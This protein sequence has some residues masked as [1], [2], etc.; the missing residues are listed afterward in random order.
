LINLAENNITVVESQAFTDLYLA[1]V[2][3]SHNAL[4]SIEP[5]AFQNCNNMTVLDL[6]YN[7]LVNIS[8]SAF[9]ENSYASELQ[10]SYNKFSDFGQ[11]STLNFIIIIT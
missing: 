11:V 4:S 2:N 8:R 6:S 10:V 7:N 1:V 3:I 9:D 5:G